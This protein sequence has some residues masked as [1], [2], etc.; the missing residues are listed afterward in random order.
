MLSGKKQKAASEGE[1]RVSR[2]SELATGNSGPHE[3]DLHHLCVRWEATSPA[4]T[5]P[6]QQ[7]TPEQPH[8]EYVQRYVCAKCGRIT[9]EPIQKGNDDGEVQ[10]G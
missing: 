3:K 6:P 8:G 5:P 7:C 2:H 10:N 1:L 4:V 9:G